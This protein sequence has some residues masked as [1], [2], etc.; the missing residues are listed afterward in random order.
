M[1]A[2]TSPGHLWY[3][4]R[5]S[6]VKGPFP[7]AA[8]EKNLVL[9]RIKASDLISQDMDNWLA[10]PDWQKAMGVGL[11]SDAKS[12][13]ARFDERR[14]ERRRLRKAAAVNDEPQ[15]RQDG[16]RREDEEQ[17][18]I[19]RRAR[20]ERVWNSLRSER[21]SN[22]K[23]LMAVAACIGIVGVLAV[24]IPATGQVEKADCDQ[25]TQPGINWDFC[26]R[27]RRDLRQV[28]LRGLTARNARMPGS[29][30]AGAKL[31]NADLAYADFS[32]STFKLADLKQAR[33]VGVNFSNADLSYADLR[34]ADLQFADFTGA[35]LTGTELAETRLGNAIWTDGRLCQRHSIGRC[36]FSAK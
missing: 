23:P 25:M 4:K 27:P 31:S 28:D 7:F 19:E 12:G 35:D 9:G 18:V 20:S 5:G 34:A 15:L 1:S 8:V 24:L 21:E 17:D 29:D 32:A 6:N 33:L 10:A 11:N 36:I 2:D 14:A 26:H 16:D 22:V 13:R 3:I 30:L